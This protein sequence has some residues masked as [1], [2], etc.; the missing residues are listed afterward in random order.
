MAPKVAAASEFALTSGRP[1]GI[2]RVEDA[3]RI[4]E[5]ASGTLVVTA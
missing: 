5:G 2:G 1:A 4:L 3:A